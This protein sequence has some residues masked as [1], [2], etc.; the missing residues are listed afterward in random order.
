MGG[1]KILSLH[2]NYLTCCS[3]RCNL[4][5]VYMTYNVS[6]HN[7]KMWSYYMHKSVGFQDY[8]R[9]KYYELKVA[10]VINEVFKSLY[11]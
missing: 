4:Y 7:V 6:E 5:L 3:L 10:V 8:A 1:A 2:N 11:W 9:I